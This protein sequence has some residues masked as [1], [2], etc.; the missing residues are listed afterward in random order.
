MLL[1]QSLKRVNSRSI[2]C[3]KFHSLGAGLDDVAILS[4]NRVADVDHGLAICLVINRTAAGFDVQSTGKK[5][6]DV[7]TVKEG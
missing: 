3:V 2:S 1:L 5:K 6:I 4:A 7:K